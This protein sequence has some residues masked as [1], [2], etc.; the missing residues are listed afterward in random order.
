MLACRETGDASA[1]DGLFARYLPRVRRLVASRLGRSPA[2]LASVDDLVQDTF[3]D[4][5]DSA[6]RVELRSDGAFCNWLAQVVGNN[7]RDHQRRA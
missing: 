4:A 1:L 3:R 7:V 5:V 6:D 2:A